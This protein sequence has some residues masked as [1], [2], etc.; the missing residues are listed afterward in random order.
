[1]SQE[2]FIALMGIVGAII[3]AI[4]VALLNRKK[5]RADTLK[6]VHDMQA[7]MIDEFRE[8]RDEH[9]RMIKELKSENRQCEFDRE[10][11]EWERQQ[12]KKQINFQMWIKEKVFV[13]DDN[14]LVAKTFKKMFAK[15]EGIECKVFTNNE[16]FIKQA[17]EEKPEAMIL[18]YFLGDITAEHIIELLGYEPEVFIMSGDSSV[19]VKV[20]GTGLQF[21]DKDNELL[22][23]ETITRAVLKHI[24][25]KHKA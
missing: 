20:K 18:D 1:M 19:R 3:G 16:V 14:E 24:K 23:V 10:V 21:F 2:V 15:I 12:I 7:Q 4:V 6:V 17:H 13:L 5:T 8:E 9:R 25:E 11:A 22:Y